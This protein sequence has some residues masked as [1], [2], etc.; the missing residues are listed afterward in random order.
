MMTS[1]F[2]MKY[3]VKHIAPLLE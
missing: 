2:I 3:Y 1:I